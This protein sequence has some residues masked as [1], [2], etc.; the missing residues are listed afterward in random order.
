M[1]GTPA[2]STFT[3][4]PSDPTTSDLYNQTAKLQQLVQDTSSSVAAN[5]SA[6]DSS[7]SDVNSQLQKI[8]SAPSM[9]GTSVQSIRSVP[10][11]SYL[12]VADYTVVFYV[13]VA[14]IATLPNCRVAE[15]Q[16]FFVKNDPRSGATV[17]LNSQGNELVDNAAA[18]TISL[19][20][21]KSI[22]L[23]SD[24]TN[25]MILSLIP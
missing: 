11:S 1:A 4:L 24:G 18:N 15:G 8:N 14:A 3:R 6:V 25:W 7:I 5:K 2:R 21:G 16:I 22:Q 13:T 20:A 10:Q 23:Q 9:N 12:T 19:A 17:T